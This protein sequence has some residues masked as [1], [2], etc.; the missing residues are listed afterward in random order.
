MSLWRICDIGKKSQDQHFPLF[1]K[2]ITI[3]G[4]FSIQNNVTSVPIGRCSFYYY[5]KVFSLL[6]KKINNGDFFKK[7]GRIMVKKAML[8]LG[9]LL[10]VSSFTYAEEEY[11][12]SGEVYFKH[13]SDIYMN[14]VTRET[15][16]NRSEP[17]PSPFGI[18]IKLTP[19][20]IKAKKFPFEFKKIPKG[21]YFIVAFEDLNK[22]KK[23]DRQ[24]SL[25]TEPYGAYKKFEFA[26]EWDK[27]KFIVDKDITGITINIE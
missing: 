3:D 11:S 22:N 12:I 9:F 15:F 6:I 10:M 21:I 27:I 25:P 17:L 8:F 18:Y 2:N 13:D 24:G 26:P 14:L 5:L 20:Q 23:L 1:Y 7:R 4:K 19:E 16:A